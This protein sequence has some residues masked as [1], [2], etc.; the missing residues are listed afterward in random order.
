[1]RGTGPTIERRALISRLYAIALTSTAGQLKVLPAFAAG[2][3]SS[4]SGKPRPETGVVLLDPV[5]QTGR[6]IS[7]ELLLSAAGAKDSLSAVAV[8]ETP[9]PV[10]KGNYYD[11]ES[12]NQEGDSAFIHVAKL[13]NSQ[14]LETAPASFFTGTALGATGRFASYSAPQITSAKASPLNPEVDAPQDG[15]SSGT[16]LVEVSFNALTQ[17]GFEVPRRGVIAALQP[18]GSAD[19]L[20]L[21]CTVAAAKWKKG[22]EADVRLAANTFRVARTRPSSLEKLNDNDYR[23]AARSLRGFSE[24]ES[25]I[26]AALARDLSTQSGDLTGKFSQAAAASSS[27]TGYSYQNAQGP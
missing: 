25:E 14:R 13:P 4:L 8:F 7:A 27:V 20:M 1:M 9:W 23:Y 24:G 2:G 15:L 18:T 10:A 11:V 19:V 3:P 16:R 5:Q 21:V 12:R 17:S 26:E 22:G 6:T